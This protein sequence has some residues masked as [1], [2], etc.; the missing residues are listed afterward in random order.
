M[1]QRKLGSCK[2]VTVV[3]ITSVDLAADVTGVLPVANGGN[4]TGT[5]TDGQILVGQTTGNT[6]SKKSLSGAATMD[7]DGVVTVVRST[8]ITPFAS[9]ETVATGDGTIGFCVPSSMNGLNLTAVT[10]SVVTAGGTAGTT[11]IQVRRLRGATAADMLSTKVTLSISE[12]S[13]SDG[14]PNPSFDDVA[15]GDLIFIDVDTINT[16]APSGLSVALTFGP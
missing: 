7:K 16:V 8:C 10:A 9:N 11:D 4:G 2:N 3:I 13:A 1:A 14:I 12:Y 6:L 15:T 5:F